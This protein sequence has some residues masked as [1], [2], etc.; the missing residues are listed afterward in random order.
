MNTWTQ[1]QQHVK[2]VMEGALSI[3]LGII[4]LGLIN[5]IASRRNIGRNNRGSDRTSCNNGLT[6]RENNLVVK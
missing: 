3:P 5:V 2:D 6:K 4:R 1:P